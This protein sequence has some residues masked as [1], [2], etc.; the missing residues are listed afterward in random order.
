MAVMFTAISHPPIKWTECSALLKVLNA[1]M[2]SG[3]SGYQLS[4]EQNVFSG[5]DSVQ[6]RGVLVRWV[7][8]RR[9]VVMV[10]EDTQHMIN[11]LKLLIA[12]AEGR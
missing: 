7:D 4:V 9:D 2:L 5:Q 8:G 3:G 12:E 10:T 1:L 11:V 6:Q